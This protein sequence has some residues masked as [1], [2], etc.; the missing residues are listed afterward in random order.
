[1]AI[2][3]KIQWTEATWNPWHGCTK[4][5]PG[6]KFCYMYRDKDRYGQDP[7]TVLRSKTKFKAPLSW[8]EP[9]L[10]FTCS[11]SD[12]FIEEADQWRDAAWKVIKD[13]PQ[14]TYQI[15]TKRPERIKGCL[16]DDWGSGYD[17]VWL[18]V[19]VENQKYAKRIWHLCHTP[20]KVRFISAEPL[21]GRID[22]GLDAYLANEDGAVIF[23]KKLQELIHWVIIGG[24]S[25][26]ETGKY[27]YRP[28]ELGW[29]EA[30]IDQCKE[31]NVPV[32]VKQLG[33]QLA[34]DMGLKDRHGGKI[35]EWPDWLQIREMPELI[36]QT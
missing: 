5:S 21:I 34:K 4:V 36:H 13:T 30:I 9:K 14:H 20:A 8:N 3:S 32:F 2:Q 15:L 18:G 29:I 22:L 7:T 28:C 26:N 12:W 27:G 16:P 1:M 17:N 35:E 24:E 6:C 10:I 23:E 31:S 33:T 11:W 19:S 25:G